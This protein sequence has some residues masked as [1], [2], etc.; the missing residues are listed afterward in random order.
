MSELHKL[1]GDVAHPSPQRDRV[2][3]WL[4][5]TSLLLA[6]FVWAIQILCSYGLTSM[7][8]FPRHTPLGGTQVR[9][10]SVIVEIGSV[11][12]L[13]L[14]AVAI[15][16]AVTAWRRTRGERSGDGHEALDAG[17][18]R[19]RFLALC[20]IIITGLFTAA[21]VWEAIVA[22]FLPHCFNAVS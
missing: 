12:A 1:A 18:G 22:I 7:S 11:V 5:L 6:P 10:M 3:P 8:C 16:A 21:I 14:A 15:W 2:S 13:C 17:E 19:T 9:G 4:L 20:G